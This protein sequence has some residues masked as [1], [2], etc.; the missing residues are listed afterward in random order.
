MKKTLI[1]LYYY[2]R[3]LINLIIL[4]FDI[5]RLI[6]FLSTKK[7][8]EIYTLFKGGFGHTISEP[9]FMNITNDVNWLIIIALDKNFHNKNI[10]KLFGNNIFFIKKTSIFW[11]Y[12]L[13]INFFLSKLI[14]TLFKKKVVDVEDFILKKSEK[15]FPNDFHKMI[16]SITF[17]KFNEF[18]NHDLYKDKIS[19]KRYEKILSSFEFKKGIINFHLRGKASKTSTNDGLSSFRDSEEINFYKDTIEKIISQG[20]L[21]IITGEINK[22]PN[23]VSDQKKKII[24]FSSLKLN[25]DDYNFFSL[26]VSEIYIGPNSGPI[27]FNLIM[28]EKKTLL[29]NTLPFGHGHLN[30]IVSYPIFD[31]KSLNEFKNSFMYDL[32]YYINKSY[33]NLK[34]KNMRRLNKKETE[35]IIF[36]FLKN[37]DSKYGKSLEDIKIN[38][39]LIESCSFKISDKWLELIKY[40]NLNHGK[41]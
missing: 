6:F 5:I 21:I 11:K 32:Y 12:H 38:N 14:Y 26:I 34:K 2:V 17:P 30:S 13:E 39:G 29:L 27:M 33:E 31:F 25:K 35:E 19:K 37:I 1:K 24:T 23:W 36:D 20:W 3:F 18:K 40:Q 7:K 41:R 8:Q 22:V 10:K 16:E 9:H 4:F 15:R 28:P